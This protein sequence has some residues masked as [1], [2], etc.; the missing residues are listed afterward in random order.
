MA[1]RINYEMN[2]ELKGILKE[3]SFQMMVNEMG[4]LGIENSHNFALRGNFWTDTN[5]RENDFQANLLRADKK[6]FQLALN[7]ENLLYQNGFRHNIRDNGPDAVEI[8]AEN[9]LN[10]FN[11]KYPLSWYVE[12]ED[13]DGLHFGYVSDQTIQ[14]NHEDFLRKIASTSAT[15]FEKER[16]R[17]IAEYYLI[18]RKLVNHYFG[19]VKVE[20]IEEFTGEKLPE[21]QPEQEQTEQRTR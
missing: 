13:R 17:N 10:K 2:D 9:Y 4:K 21:V 5:F 6:G 11:L 1:N 15:D 3:L 19:H 8:W 14:N 18:N 16:M 12:F 20:G 7:Y